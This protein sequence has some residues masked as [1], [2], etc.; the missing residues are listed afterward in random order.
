MEFKELPTDILRV[1]VEKH[2]LQQRMREEDDFLEK[3]K[4]FILDYIITDDR[5]RCNFRGYDVRI[6]NNEPPWGVAVMFYSEDF[7]I[8]FFDDT[9]RECH[10]I[11]TRVSI[12]DAPRPYGHL[13]SRIVD[14]IND[15]KNTG[16][17]MFNKWM[18]K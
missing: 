2:N 17:E 18:L 1:I 12:V 11:G 6:I 7:N 14:L 4:G 5:P 13:E 15:V 8:F 9:I 16:P 10:K 3:V